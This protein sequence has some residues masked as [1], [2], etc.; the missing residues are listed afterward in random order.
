MLDAASKA[1]EQMLSQPFRAVLL[2]SAGLACLLLLV[3]GVVLDRVLVSVFEFA[4][5]WI[6]AGL[7]SH[8][9]APMHFLG[10]L[11]ALATGLGIVAGAVFLMP[12]VTALTA[13]LFVDEIAGEVERVY[14]PADAPGQGLPIVLA[15]IE[16]FKAA[17]LSLAVYLCAVPLLLVVGFGFVIFFLATAYVQGRI[18]FEFAAM[19]F[20]PVTEAKRLRRLHRW[21]VFVGGLFIAG[22]LS[23]PVL[24]LA[25]PLFGTAMMVH[26]YKRVALDYEMARA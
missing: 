3:I 1:L 18:Y 8:A 24:S 7:G 6:E 25:A 12:V 11:L 10:W 26:L 20:H 23:I 17:L 9:H 21:T 16:G 14:Y 13:S 4:A 5:R 22:F 15:F 19:R 2:K